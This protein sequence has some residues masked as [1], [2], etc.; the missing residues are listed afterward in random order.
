MS[1]HG[2]IKIPHRKPPKSPVRKIH[3]GTAHAKPRRPH[4]VKPPKPNRPLKP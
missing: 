1:R 3:A 2:D 4:S